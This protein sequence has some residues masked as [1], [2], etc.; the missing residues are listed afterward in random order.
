MQPHSQSPEQSWV[1]P[2]YMSPEQVRGAP[3]TPASDVFSLGCVAYE[4]VTGRRAFFRPT[5][6]ESL[7]TLLHEPAPDFQNG[8]HV[9][10]AELQHIVRRCLEKDPTARFGS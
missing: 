10:P 3:A 7:A 1:P 8:V 5:V 4:M 6:A 2:G 9:I